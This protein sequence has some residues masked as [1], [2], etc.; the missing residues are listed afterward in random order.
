MPNANFDHERAI[1]EL[2]ADPGN[3]A[4]AQQVFDLARTDPLGAQEA[5]QR[6]APAPALIPLDIERLPFHRH[7][8]FMP[9]TPKVV[10]GPA[11][12]QSLLAT[13]QHAADAWL[14]IK[15]IGDGFGF[16]NTGDTRG[17]LLP[18]VE[19][20][21]RVLEV[22][23][24]VLKP[25]VDAEHLCRFE[26]GAT[27]QTINDYLWPRGKALLNQPGYER[28]TYVGTMSSGGHGSGAWCGPLS[29]HVRALH[30]VTVDANRRALQFQI[31]PSDGISDPGQFKAKNP[32]V[33]LVQDD[34]MFRACAVS[35]GCLGVIY[36]VTIQVRDGY[37]ILENR[38]KFRFS[39]L[40]PRLPALLAEQGPGKRLHSI[41]IWLN[42]YQVDGDVFC[43]L[44]ERSE[45]KDPPRGERALVVEYGGPEFLYR[46]LSWW[47]AHEP[48]AVPALVGVAMTATQASNVVLT[49]PK[50]LNFGAPNLAPVTACSCAVPSDH[51][52]ELTDDLIAFFQ[53][54]AKDQSLY[55]TS[56]LGLRFVKGASAHLS[57]AYGR[58]TCMI[59][60]PTLL[61]TPK[62]RETL[63]AYHDFLFQK[64]NGRPHWGQVNDMPKERLKALYPKLPAF[65]ESFRVLNPIGLFDNAFTEQMGFRVP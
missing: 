40:K 9:Q 43:V 27:I 65:L 19:R 18:M 1:K 36:S 4:K 64:Y 29:E 20:L 49:A 6:V 11:D 35:M 51:I 32:G 13:V 52:G 46:L 22:D 7:N 58:D 61:G 28:L 12:L 21:N 24:S 30:I 50:G 55:I 63:N 31:E 33:E 59:E 16:G 62:A 26:A 60:V 10:T 48:A 53:Q 42:P 37:N 54:R 23:K 3:T 14:Q 34:D 15:A 25:S 57:P 38:R 41:E 56:P 47:M 8:L 39:E 2:S 5:Q 45:T 17:Y 44:G